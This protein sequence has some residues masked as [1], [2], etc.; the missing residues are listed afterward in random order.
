MSFEAITGEFPLRL[1]VW[2]LLLKSF[3]WKTY[4]FFTGFSHPLCR[5]KLS[6]GSFPWDSKYES[7]YQKVFC[8]KPT[9]FTGFSHP[10]FRLKLSRGSFPWDLMYQ[11]VFDEK[12]YSFFTGFS[13]PCLVWSYHEGVSPETRGMKVVIKKLE[14][15]GYWMA[16]AL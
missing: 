12:P 13:H 6:R 7:C 10:L 11:K 16:K 4:S 3:W 9:V 1:R 5:L 8:E 2:K 15:L 14:F